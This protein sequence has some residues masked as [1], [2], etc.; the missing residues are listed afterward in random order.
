MV[1]GSVTYAAG[2][3]PPSGCSCWS[4]E[5]REAGRP[6]ICSPRQH[7]KVDVMVIGS[8][9]PA[10]SSV[11]FGG[12]ATVLGGGLGGVWFVSCRTGSHKE[13]QATVGQA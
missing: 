10:A 13:S 2:S 9:T 1:A 5:A 8:H 3:A 4:A 7:A 12:L 11:L 6:G